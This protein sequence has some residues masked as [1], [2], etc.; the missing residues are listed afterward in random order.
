VNVFEALAHPT[1]RRILELL[2][3]RDMSAGEIAEHFDVSKPTLSGHFDKLRRAD[4]VLAERE[5]TSIIY[6]LNLSVVEDA[7]IGLLGR[8]GARRVDDVEERD[9]AR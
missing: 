8:L 4:L 2:R 9:H 3:D 6:S 1:R 7:L 5:G